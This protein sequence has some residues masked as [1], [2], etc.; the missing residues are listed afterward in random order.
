MVLGV[1]VVLAV[2]I[3][4]GLRHNGGYFGDCI[5]LAAQFLT[6]SCGKRVIINTQ[7]LEY[8]SVLGQLLFQPA[9]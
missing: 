1:G 4:L 3:V 2:E 9:L 5:P 7:R 6:L 8:A